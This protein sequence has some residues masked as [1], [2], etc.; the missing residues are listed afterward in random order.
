MA[1]VTL[2]VS[3]VSSG[4]PATGGGVD[5]QIQ[6]REFVVLAGPPGCG[7]STI[8]RMIAGLVAVPQGDLLLDGRR[9]NDVPPKDRDVAFVSHDYA[10][11]PGMSVYENLAIGLEWRKFA[12]AEIKKRI[13]AAAEILG[14]QEQLD[15]R[16]PSL[17]AGERQ[18]IA[19]AR[20]M[21]HQPKV[22]LF[23]EP[24]L[25]LEPD[26]RRRGR[27][28]IKKLHQRLPATMIYATHDPVEA[29]AMGERTVVFNEGMVRQDAKAQSIYD[30]PAD[31]FVARF[32]G[33]PPMN[34]VQGTLKLD[35]DSLLFSEAGD[36]TI[37]I[38]LPMAQVAGAKEFFGKPIVL[39][40]R[41]EDIEIALASNGV[42]HSFTIFRALVDRVELRGAETDLC[43]Q[44]GAHELICRSRRWVD[45]AEGGG[46]R[47]Q[48]EIN[49]GR[50][51]LFD[52]ASGR[53]IMQD[54]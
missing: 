35:R 31:L 54:T 25:A 53:R 30:E 3:T 46:H 2:K 28:E 10:L 17:S 37:A 7:N 11:Y 9:I 48:F 12:K 39:G 23:D 14:L 27:A 5:L 33:V 22:F 21:V 34:L 36:G 16:P 26:V 19:L 38:R 47:F 45:Q 6:D 24:F 51:H 52:A 41:P 49:L 8:L 13:L 50:A 29:M 32:A 4:E 20:A 42:R 43:L 1:S 44:T 18:L 40:I 15:G